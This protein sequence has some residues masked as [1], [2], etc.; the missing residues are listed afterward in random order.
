MRR[1]GIRFDAW[2][3]SKKRSLCWSGFGV[4]F[5]GGCLDTRFRG[6]S[7]QSVDSS[8]WLAGFMGV[9]HDVGGMCDD[10]NE[11]EVESWSCA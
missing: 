9:G 11:S 1:V 10:L 4:A 2:S 7:L 6:L 8:H 3:E 5:G